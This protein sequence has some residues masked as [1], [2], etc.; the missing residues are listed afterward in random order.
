LPYAP[1]TNEFNSLRKDRPTLGGTPTAWKCHP[2]AS[3]V[4]SAEQIF[5]AL[6]LAPESIG[7]LLLVLIAELIQKDFVILDRPQ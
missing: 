2:A 6:V 1:A 7:G 3:C 5:A 4:I